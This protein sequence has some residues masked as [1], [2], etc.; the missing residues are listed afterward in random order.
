MPGVS[1]VASAVFKL[2][3]FA[4]IYT[5]EPATVN[6]PTVARR[7]SLAARVDQLFNMFTELRRQ[8]HLRALVCL[9]M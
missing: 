8:L 5:Q 2:A 9:F 4:R 3:A 7:L 6:P 1:Q